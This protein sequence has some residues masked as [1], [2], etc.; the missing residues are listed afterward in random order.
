MI[1]NPDEYQAITRLFDLVCGGQV[2]SSELALLDSQVAKCLELAYQSDE[3]PAIEG[4]EFKR[5]AM[6][7]S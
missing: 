4:M 7:L 3:A 5:R 6:S 2:D 1:E